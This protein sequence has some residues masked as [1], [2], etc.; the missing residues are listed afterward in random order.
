MGRAISTE[1][2]RELLKLARQLRECAAYSC[3]QEYVDM[4]LRGAMALEERAA[5]RET[6]AFGSAD[7]GLRAPVNMLV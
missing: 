3:D 6:D 1:E 5:L 4:F 7:I 2:L